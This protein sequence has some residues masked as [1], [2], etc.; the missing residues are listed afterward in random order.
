M[1]VWGPGWGQ[2]EAEDSKARKEPAGRLESRK[3]LVRAWMVPW[4]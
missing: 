4:G 3:E 2:I 1:A